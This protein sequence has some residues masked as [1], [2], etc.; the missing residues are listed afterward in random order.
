MLVAKR[1]EQS[2][3]GMLLQAARIK[4]AMAHLGENPT[5]HELADNS[6]APVRGQR[7]AAVHQLP[8]SVIHDLL[9]HYQ[10]VRVEGRM[11]ALS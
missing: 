10:Y 5:S 7:A 1:V 11:Q 2:L 6:L 4:F 9:K 3:E 8:P